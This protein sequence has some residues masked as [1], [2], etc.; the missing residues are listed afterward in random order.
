MPD[1]VIGDQA[2][3]VMNGNVNSRNI[4]EYASKGQPPAFHYDKSVSR[5]K[6]IVWIGLLEMGI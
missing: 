5:E 6:L 4:I 2:A 3:F 1:L